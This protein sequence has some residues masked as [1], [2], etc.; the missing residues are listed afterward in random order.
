ME[1]P[2]EHVIPQIS[3]FDGISG[4]GARRR[5]PLFLH[6]SQRSHHSFTFTKPTTAMPRI[7]AFACFVFFAVLAFIAALE[8]GA[9]VAVASP[10]QRPEGAL[11]VRSPGESDGH[12]DQEDDDSSH[13]L[14]HD[15]VD[16]RYDQN[17]NGVD[18]RY[19]AKYRT[20]TASKP[21]VRSCSSVRQHLTH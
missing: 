20:K 2:A 18:D 13:D 15:G 1:D 6:H 17:H 4:G 12:D 7:L 16:D 10:V 14:N 11:A 21:K 8:R 19:E 3:A 9:G 5:H